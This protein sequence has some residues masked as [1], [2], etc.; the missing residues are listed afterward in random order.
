MLYFAF[1]IG[2]GANIIVGTCV[3]A[4]VVEVSDAVC[5]G[6]WCF[7]VV[8]GAVWSVVKVLV[9]P[10]STMAVELNVARIAEDIAFSC[11]V[12]HSARRHLV[13]DLLASAV[14]SR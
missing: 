8:V 14:L 4:A 3:G 7:V 13:P 11:V 2:G 1:V 10:F 5:N 12:P 9:V 6:L